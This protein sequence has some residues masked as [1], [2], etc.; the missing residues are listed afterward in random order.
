MDKTKYR[1]FKEKND[2]SVKLPPLIDMHRGLNRKFS[3][4]ESWNSIQH[5]VSYKMLD[6]SKLLEH[7]AYNRLLNCTFEE[8]FDSINSEPYVPLS[9]LDSMKKKDPL[10]ISHEYFSDSFVE[11]ESENSSVTCDNDEDVIKTK[12]KEL[13]LKDKNKNIFSP[14][15][16][17]WIQNL[18][19][20]I[21]K[22][23]RNS[24]DI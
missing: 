4:Y 24:S 12:K 20:T 7:S 1:Y 6:K 8:M 21:N 11:E 23:C 18:F 10:Q 3:E 15:V 13:K 2:T 17:K 16:D 9:M 22:N 19:L 5:T 14:E